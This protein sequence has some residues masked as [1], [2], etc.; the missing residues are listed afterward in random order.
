MSEIGQEIRRLREA[1]GWSQPKLAVTAG[2]AVSGVSQIENGKRN[3][4]SSTLVKLAG[5]LGVEVRDLY[6]KVQAPLPLENGKLIDRADVQEWLRANGHMTKD[7]FL[8]WAEDLED[9]ADIEQA[10][11]DLRA[12]RDE[13]RAAVR[14]S[15]AREVLFPMPP[16][17]S[18]EKKRTWLL[19]PPGL[20][21]LR[22]EIQREYLARELA[23][24]NYSKELFVLGRSPG[25]L[26]Y[27]PPDGHA[28]WDRHRKMLEARRAFEE[29]YAKALAV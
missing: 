19:K 15:Y 11:L 6:P 28:A 27:G 3:P 24:V 7:D 22:N 5:A 20:W 26:G 21:E 18:R 10:I 12:R 29:S 4:N 9:E 1:K 23:L 2:V 13:L 16:G 14:T 17:L 25:Y 8:A